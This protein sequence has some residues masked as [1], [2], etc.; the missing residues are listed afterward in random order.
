VQDVKKVI[1]KEMIEAAQAVVYMEPEK[2]I[3][4][5]C[6]MFFHIFILSCYINAKYWTYRSGDECVVALCDQWYLDYGKGV[7]RERTT[8]AL[9]KTETYHDEVRK[10]FTATL[11]WLK[12]HACSRTYGLGSKLPW[13]EKWLIES[14]SDSTIYM[15]YY[16]VAHLLQGNTFDGRGTLSNIYKHPTFVET[17]F[18]FVMML[19]CRRKRLGDQSRSN[20]TRGLGLHFLQRSIPTQ[21][22]DS[23][24]EIEYFEERIQF[25]VSCRLARIRQGLGSQPFDLFSIQPCCH[26]AKRTQQV[27]NNMLEKISEP[28]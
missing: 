9:A 22:Y 12:E 28:I 13:D 19:H 27:I 1:Q 21:D 24:R 26:L 16:T 14:L 7:W 3:I 17:F 10:N 25:L 6:V 23:S 11:D 20:D 2:T 5:R 15:A 4:S 18:Y 8:E